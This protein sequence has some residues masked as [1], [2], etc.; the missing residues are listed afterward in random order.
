MPNFLC[1]NDHLWLSTEHICAVSLLKG[2]E[3]E[4]WMA[5]GSA[6]PFLLKDEERTRV[7]EYVM[8]H[9]PQPPSLTQVV[10]RCPTLRMEGEEDE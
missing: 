7:L 1:V 10:L 5:D 4:V 2:G 8:R 9:T 6:E 3:A